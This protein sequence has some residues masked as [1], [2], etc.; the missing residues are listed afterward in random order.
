MASARD[1][2]FATDGIT[3]YEFVWELA[4]TRHTTNF[5]GT[6]GWARIIRRSCGDVEPAAVEPA[7]AA[8][9]VHLCRHN[10]C[11]AMWAA[12]KYGTM[13]VPRHWQPTDWRPGTVAAAADD[14]TLATESA[15]LVGPTSGSAVEVPAVAGGKSIPAASVEV[16]SAAVAE[17]PADAMDVEMGAEDRVDLVSATITLEASIPAVAV[18]GSHAVGELGNLAVAEEPAAAVEVVV[19]TAPATSVA[20][21]ESADTCTPGE[22]AVVAVAASG[23][24]AEGSPPLP[25]PRVA[26]LQLRRA[27]PP[28]PYQT[29]QTIAAVAAQPR[30]SLQLPDEAECKVLDSLLKLAREVRRPC[31]FIGY[32]AFLCFALHYRYRVFMWEGESRV[33]IIKTF[34]PWAD[35]LE[36]HDTDVD[37]VC[38]CFDPDV[39]EYVRVSEDYPVSKVSHFVAAVHLERGAGPMVAVG[40]RAGSRLEAFYARLGVV[41]L[42]TVC[43]GDCGVDVMCQMLGLPQDAATRKHVRQEVGDYL[44]QRVNQEWMQNM[45]VACGELAA[46]DVDRFRSVRSGGQAGP[47]Q[48]PAIAAEPHAPAVAAEPQSTAVA[49]EGVVEVRDEMIDFS[50]AAGQAI[51]KALEWKICVKDPAV[52]RGVAESLPLEVLQEQVREYTLAEKS[53]EKPQSRDV[54]RVLPGLLQSRNQAVNAYVAHLRSHGAEHA[55]RVPQSVLEGFLARTQWPSPHHRAKAA[56]YLREWRKA[57]AAD[58]AGADYTDKRGHLTARPGRK[59]SKLPF[60]KRRRRT[61]HQGPQYQCPWLREALYSWFTSMRYSIDWKAAVAG[62][63]GDPRKCLARFTSGLLQGKARQLLQDYCGQSLLNG[64]RPRGV[65]IT[66]KWLARWCADYGL[67]LRKP[68]RKYKVPKAVMA[69][70]LEIGWL[71]VARVRALCLLAHGYEPELENWDQSPFHHNETGSQNTPTLAVAGSLVPVLEGHHDTRERWTANLTTFSNKERLLRDGPP[72]AEFVFKGDGDRMASRLREHIRSRGHPRWVSTATSEKGSYRVEDVLN[73]LELHL[74][75][76]SQ[77]R[78]WRIIMADDHKPHLSPHVWRLCWQR[79][80][81]FIPHGGGVTP[82]AQTVDTD[83]NQSVKREYSLLETAELLEQ[84]RCGIVVPRCQQEQCIDMMVQVLSNMALHLAAAD[85]Y[86]K[87]GFLA[88]LDSSVGDQFIVREAGKFWKELGMRDKLDAAVADVREEFQNGRLKWTHTDVKRLILPFPRHGKVDE[89]LERMGDDTAEADGEV[90]FNN[91]SDVENDESDFE[92]LPEVAVAAGADPEAAVAAEP[93]PGAAG[94]DPHLS[95]TAGAAEVATDSAQL[96]GAFE[97]AATVLRDVGAMSQV[98]ALENEIAKERRR[99]RNLGREDPGVLQALAALQDAASARAAKR[100]R[101]IEDANAKQVTLGQLNAKLRK[102]RTD[103]VA[104]R[105]AIA[106]AEALVETRHAIKSFSLKELGGESSGGRSRGGA[107]AAKKRRLEVLERMARLGSGLSPSQ[108]N[109]FAWWKGAWD[110]A[111]VAEYGENW[112]HTFMGWLQDVLTRIENGESNAFS[113]FVFNET[114]RW[115][116]QEVEQLQEG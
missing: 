41:V 39:Q 31:A 28:M 50:S 57:A 105:K 93:A 29:E 4:P 90:P 54:I 109:D 47:L 62:K 15:P 7:A 26:P 98:V 75:P 94:A 76:M 65:G 36:L 40:E 106:E 61:T 59:L 63:G 113:V 80:Y 12:N 84:M 68:N 111:A 48:P 112:P 69:E 115:L 1:H 74:P 56:R 107:A 55:K 53:G 34:A 21:G 78:R 43:D 27:A 49:A 72:Y 73:F 86:E 3:C 79:G 45:M 14:A 67:C 64:V 8:V 70:R 23:G 85:G 81:V 38:C 35:S 96:I 103:L 104:K 42:G 13:P 87:T 51:L 24:G 58:G 2:L 108:R 44:L 110:D 83:L 82:V 6:T 102:A 19:A 91:E 116:E 60:H 52:L 46:E 37:G 77:S 99:A 20:G 30:G 66:S 89:A 114:R 71:N 97:A 25:P 33:D 100:R 16:G 18:G 22:T 10:P 9:R 88:G 11:S 92:V 101:M 17:E 5:N 95:D 32:S